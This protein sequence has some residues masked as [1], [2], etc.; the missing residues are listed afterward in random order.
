MNETEEKNKILV[1]KLKKIGVIEHES[2]N[3]NPHESDGKIWNPKGHPDFENLISDNIEISLLPPKEVENILKTTNID[4]IAY[5]K[6]IHFYGEKNWGIV[7]NLDKLKDF[8]SL[9]KSYLVKKFESESDFKMFFARPTSNLAC[10]LIS[11]E[12]ILRH[13]LY[14]HSMESFAIKTELARSYDY[15]I[16]KTG[17]VTPSS[18]GQPSPFKNY[19]DLKKGKGIEYKGIRFNLDEALATKAEENNSSHNKRMRGIIKERII[20]PMRYKGDIKNKINEIMREINAFIISRHQ[21]IELDNYK[22]VNIIDNITHAEN[23]AKL[24]FHAI[25]DTLPNIEPDLIDEIAQSISPI[26]NVNQL[27]NMGKITYEVNNSGYLRIWSADFKSLPGD[28]DKKTIVTLLN[29]RGFD[30]VDNRGSGSHELFINKKTGLKYMLTSRNKVPWMP[31]LR[32][33]CKLLEI[34]FKDFHCS[35][36]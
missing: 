4:T 36:R 14:H 16:P 21:K 11:H 13:E 30:Y 28:C 8:T 33:L 23:Q 1:D 7:F 22:E 27:K 18:I 9:L 5:Y 29:R 35:M 6:P 10:F 32:K 19:W 31:Y 26:F 17:L 3:E 2:D 20:K 25:N 24:T 12:I 15:S 34:K